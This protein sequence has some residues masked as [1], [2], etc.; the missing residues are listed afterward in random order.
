MFRKVAGGE[1]KQQESGKVASAVLGRLPGFCGM[2]AGADLLRSI[3]ILRSVQSGTYTD[4]LRGIENVITDDGGDTL[5]SQDAANV[6][7]AAG[8]AGADVIYGDGGP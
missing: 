7:T 1:S 8:G 4:T 6:L 5:A 3:G 2:T